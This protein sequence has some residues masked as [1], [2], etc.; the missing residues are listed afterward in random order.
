MK[1]IEVAKY[2]RNST[3]WANA[4]AD[5][6]TYHFVEL[7]CTVID[8]DLQDE[9]E[10][11]YGWEP[12]KLINGEGVQ[13]HK[14][15]KVEGVGVNGIGTVLGIFDDDRDSANQLVKEVLNA[16]FFKGWRRVK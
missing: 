2:E 12:A 16:P 6:K 4:R 8:W 14:R 1:M 15:Y 3:L 9:Q 5:K 7:I 11:K 13:V 10:A